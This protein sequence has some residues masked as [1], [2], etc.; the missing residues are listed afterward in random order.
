M[1]DMGTRDDSVAKVAPIWGFVAAA[2]L[3]G[4]IQFATLPAHPKMLSVINNFAHGPVFGAAAFGLLVWLRPHFGSRPWFAYAGAFLL[5]VTAGIA[6]EVVQTFTRR[7]ASFADAMTNSVG[8]GCCLSVL[9]YFDRRLWRS[10]VDSRRRLALI[11]SGLLMLVL[12]VPVGHALLGYAARETRFPTIMQFTSKLDMYFIELRDCKATLVEPALQLRCYGNDWPGI[13]NIEPS[14]DWKRFRR[15]RID[16]TNAGEGELTLGLRIHDIGGG[17]FFDDRFN[18]EFELGAGIRRVLDVDL[19]DVAS[20]PV[21]RQLDL[22][23]IGELVL[24]R[25]SPRTPQASEF[26]L[27]RVWLE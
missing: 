16:V 18:T 24:F 26:I 7:D 23:R 21:N 19:A 25:V 27:T 12:L 3:V 17:E 14:P 9:A 11:A 10:R 1:G 2:A 15:L 20:S 13:S 22:S 4:L 8:A 6:L 5:A